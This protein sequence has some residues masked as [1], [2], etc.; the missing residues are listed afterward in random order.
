MKHLIFL[1]KLGDL[2]FDIYQQVPVTLYNKH[3]E[4]VGNSYDQHNQ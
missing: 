1:S 3:T 2:T 4:Q